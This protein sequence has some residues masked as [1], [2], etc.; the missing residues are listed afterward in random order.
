MHRLAEAVQRQRLNMEFDV[1]GGVIG[2]GLGEQAK[3]RRR[4]GQ[5]PAPAKAIVEPHLA[6][7]EERWV[8]D[9]ERARAGD[10]KNGSQ[11][12]MVLQIFADSRQGVDDRR[13]DRLEAI[14]V[15]HTRKL[16][17]LGR[18]DRARGQNDFPPGP[19]LV[20]CAVLAVAEARS[21]ATLEQ[22]TLDMRAGREIQVRPFE[23]RLQKRRRRAPAASAPLVDLEIARTFV[24]ALIEV[25]DLRNADLDSR[26]TH[27]I[28]DWPG[29]ARTLDPPFTARS[30][31]VGQA[32]MMVLLPE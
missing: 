25:G 29:D 24:V 17:E 8:V 12:Q 18:A 28:E 19:R 32:A 9:I 5:G 4:H 20:G 11:L 31:Q 2:R 6:A 30:M 13:A 7:L 3:L 21:A 1:G 10:A 23:N 27:R 14:R 15:A 26:L 22:D 16:Q